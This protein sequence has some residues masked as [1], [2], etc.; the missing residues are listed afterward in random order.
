MQYYSTLT[1]MMFVDTAVTYRLSVQ[2]DIWWMVGANKLFNDNN[3][4][5]EEYYEWE[6]MAEW[7]RRRT[8]DQ[9]VG[10]SIPPDGHV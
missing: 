4:N 6:R 5:E 1:S 10:G 7:L 8:L 3:I 2:I 9:R